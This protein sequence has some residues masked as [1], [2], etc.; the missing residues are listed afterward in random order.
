MGGAEH[1][2]KLERL[3]DAGGRR[4]G[5]GSGSFKRTDI[6]LEPAIGYA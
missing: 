1:F 3:Y 6:A 5:A 2:R 4:I